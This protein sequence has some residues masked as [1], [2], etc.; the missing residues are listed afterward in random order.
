M[1]FTAVRVQLGEA[2]VAAASGADP[3]VQRVAP[4]GGEGSTGSSNSLQWWG[5][6]TA[7]SCQHAAA[8]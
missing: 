7:S 5:T 3:G 2:A 8:L 1:V 4:G 6:M